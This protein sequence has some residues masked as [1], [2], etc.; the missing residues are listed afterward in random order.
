MKQRLKI[1]PEDEY[2]RIKEVGQFVGIR[3][4]ITGN[5]LMF[6]AYAKGM[7]RLQ[8]VPVD[9]VIIDEQPSEWMFSWN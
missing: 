2:V 6:K 5:R 1:L 7:T 3:H 9:L 4:K 8:S